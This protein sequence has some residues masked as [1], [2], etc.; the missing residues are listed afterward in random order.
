MR[1]R[2]GWVGLVLPLQAW[3]G[4]A[5]EVKLQPSVLLQASGRAVLDDVLQDEGFLLRRV[6]PRLRAEVGSRVKT[7][8]HVDLAGDKVQLLDAW[9]EVKLGAGLSLR[10][11]KQKLPFGI[12]RLQSPGS[13]LFL[14]RALTSEIAPNRDTGLQLL[15]TFLDQRLEAQ[16]GV[17]NGTGDAAVGETNPD[18]RLD[19]FV[20]VFGRPVVTDGLDLGVCAA[21]SYGR[22]HQDAAT[23]RFRTPAGRKIFGFKGGD[24]PTLADGD[25]LR[26]TGALYGTAGPLGVL[27]EYVEAHTALSAAD[28]HT[29]VTTRAWQTAVSFVVGGRPGYKG[30]K[31]D[32]EA[33]LGAIEL[34]ARVHGF[35]VDEAAF[36][37]L[38]SATDQASAALAVGAGL[39]WYPLPAVRVLLDAEHL[40]PEAQAGTVEDETVFTTTFQSLY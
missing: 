40:R 36:P 16:L 23:G 37:T 10:I 39:N 7:D 27:A 19:G 13:T 35:Q 15:G 24:T 3:G 17:F 20:R 33:K 31:V 21:V 6:R 8:L 12:E 1:V 18:G 32:P 34:K 5:P 38:A 2:W 28:T 14:E 4:E 9:G 25:L 29:T 26:F 11:G 22:R 30:V